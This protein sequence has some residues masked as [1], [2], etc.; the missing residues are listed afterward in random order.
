MNKLKLVWCILFWS[1]SIQSFSQKIT[2]VEIP[3][4]GNNTEIETIPVG[5]LGVLLVSKP[6]KTTFSIE[7][8]NTDFAVIWNI[9]GPVDSKYELLANTFDGQYVFLLF[10]KSGSST[11]RIIKVNIG[12]GFVESFE[13]K[14]IDKFEITEFQT[15]GYAVFMSGMIKNESVLIYFEL[16]TGQSKLLPTAFQGTSVVQSIE[17]DTLNQ[18]INVTIAV[19]KGK[20]SQI[21]GR[22]YLPDGTIYSEITATPDDDYSLLNGRIQI[23][24]DSTQLLVGTY[25]YRNLQ[26]TNT[27][28]S[29]GFY[30]SKFNHEDLIFTK[31]HSFTD[32]DNFFQ[33]MS[34][35]Q[36]EKIERKIQKKKEA[37]I[38]VKLNYTLL[39]HDLV[40]Y[41]GNYLFVAEVYYPE[42]KYQSPGMNGAYNYPMGIPYRMGLYNPYMN[43]PM[44]TGRG[45][46]RQLFD[47]FVYTHAIVAGISKEGDL[48]WDNSINFE[49]VKSMVL[50]QK[51][52][53]QNDPMGNSKLVYSKDGIIKSNV[54]Q[55]NIIIDS[56]KELKNTSLNESDKVKKTTDDDV[57]YWYGNHFISWGFQKIIN[58]KNTNTGKSRRNVYY[59]NKLTY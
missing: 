43:N 51:V 20:Q 33:F 17:L 47:G 48:L 34:D 40:P 58:I 37:G 52:K 59:L 18:H 10:G 19:K 42:F 56:N 26:S 21:I 23:L 16:N 2:R 15:I 38:D 29:Q 39:V 28:A 49:E 44:Y 41:F 25:G 3:V 32:F 35:R 46:N 57:E 9:E 24:N 1:V 30:I 6:N 8:Y 11:Y 4:N 14:P 22:S 13:I 53:L 54:I 27:P 7:R 12:P 55:E 31:Y 36:Q 50:R 45:N 5:D